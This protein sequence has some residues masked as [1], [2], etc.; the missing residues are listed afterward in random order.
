[1]LAQRGDDLRRL[2]VFDGWSKSEF[3]AVRKGRTAAIIKCFEKSL[4]RL[5]RQI[6]AL[7]GGFVLDQ[8][9]LKQ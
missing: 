6:A 5:D 2:A 9:R 7:A 4:A 8:H 1:V 3:P